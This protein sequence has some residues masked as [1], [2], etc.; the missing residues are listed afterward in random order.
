MTTIA[1]NGQEALTELGQTDFDLVL[2]DCQMPVMDGFV[3]TAAIRATDSPVRDPKIPIIA[4]TAHA[5]A[6]DR[7]RCLDA[8]MDDYLSKP[9]KSRAIRDVFGRWLAKRP[10]PIS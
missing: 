5:M 8:G 2:M 7:Q 3:A 4:L 10:A 9:L 6:E 1:G